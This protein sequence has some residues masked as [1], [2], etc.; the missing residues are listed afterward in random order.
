MLELSEDLELG[1]G[2]GEAAAELAMD[3]SVRVGMLEF[4]VT[5]DDKCLYRFLSDG[6]LHFDA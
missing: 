3:R 2:L 6:C 4:L 5:S 1:V